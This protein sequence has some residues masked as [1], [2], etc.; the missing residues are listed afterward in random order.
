MSKLLITGATGFL[1]SMLCKNLSL[2][3]YLINAS[4]R[5][6]SQ[7]TIKGIKFF[8]VGDINSKT[9]WDEALFSVECVIH[10]AARAHMMKDKKQDILKFYRKINVEGTRNLAMQAAMSG[11]KRFIFISS[12]K[13]NGEITIGSSSFKNG[14]IPKPE[15]AYGISKW[16]AEQALWKVSKQTGLEIVIIRPPLVH[17]Y[18]VKGNFLRLLNLVYRGVPLPFAGI[19]NC[20]SFIGLENLIDIIILC[21][22]HSKAAGN[23]FLISDTECIST[24][25]LIS[26]LQ[27]IMK[28]PSRLFSI[29]SNLIK[30]MGFLTGKSLEVKRLLYSLKID[31]SHA[32]KVLGWIP[33]ITLDEGLEKTV[34][35]YLKKK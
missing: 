6:D 7:K 26:K 8:N 15:D 31:S 12:I 34:K 19:D 14:D 10:C 32:Q 4:T 24:S 2:K 30:L 25:D 27:K 21:I 33:P 1:G 29:H 18:G 35:W 11:V 5:S 3:N 23:T 20:R 13:V 16:E 17:G 9:K 28:K 22:D